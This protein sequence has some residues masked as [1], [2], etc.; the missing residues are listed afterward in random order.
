MR[1][2]QIP[3]AALLVSLAFTTFIPRQAFGNG[4]MHK[5]KHI[6]DSGRTQP[7]RALRAA[8]GTDIRH[9]LHRLF[10]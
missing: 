4:G 2:F 7:A 5:V 1:L 9:G 10:G 8:W 3:R 6:I